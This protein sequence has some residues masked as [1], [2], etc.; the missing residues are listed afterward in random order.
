VIVARFVP[1]EREASREELLSVISHQAGVIDAL[2]VE[3]A[4]LRRRLGLDSTNSSKPPSSDGLKK[5]PPRSLRKASGR[6]PGKQRG[7]VGKTLRQVANPSEEFEYRPPACEACH[8]SLADA[9]VVG[10]QRRQVFELPEMR[11]RV[12]EHRVLSCRCDCGAVSTGVAPVEVKAPVQYG[13]GTAAVA[14]YLLVAHHIPF[15][16]V[17]RIMSDL[18]GCAVSAGWVASLVA[19]TATALTGFRARLRDALGRSTVVHFDETF[20]RVAGRLRFAHVACTPLLTH[21]HLDDPTKPN[22]TSA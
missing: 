7:A 17:V 22:A 20:V 3:V 11:P 2:T 15:Q 6:K 13:P 8:A 16:R 21:Y 4:E 19:R 9:D 1:V 12:I 5:P 18:L 14:I 10:V